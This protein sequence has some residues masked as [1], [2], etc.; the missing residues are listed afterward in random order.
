MASSSMGLACVAQFS[1]G[2]SPRTRSRTNCPR[3]QN[4]AD[5]LTRFADLTRPHT[6]PEVLNSAHVAPL[7]MGLCSFRTTALPWL[8]RFLRILL[9]R[10]TNR[11]SAG[12][13]PLSK[14]R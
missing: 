4:L 7:F 11:N 10:T 3:C 8:G 14:S 13:M 5:L 12:V 1:S 2:G 9:L 6:T